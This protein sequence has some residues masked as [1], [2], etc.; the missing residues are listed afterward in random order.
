MKSAI[1]V[2]DVKTSLPVEG[3]TVSIDGNALGKTDSEG[4]F[5]IP[6][7]GG[8]LKVTHINYEP[9]QF[10]IAGS[11]SQVIRMSPR[12]GD[13]PEIVITAV[14]RKENVFFLLLLLLAVALFYSYKKGLIK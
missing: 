8:M 14:K 1:T 2:L 3:A 11:M 9:E 12:S 6:A 5:E 13:L 10:D 4:F 7:Q